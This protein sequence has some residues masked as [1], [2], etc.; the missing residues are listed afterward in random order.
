MIKKL[1]LRGVL[2]NRE[3]RV[4]SLLKKETAQRRESAAVLEKA[5]GNSLPAFVAAFLKDNKL[6]LPPNG[7]SWNS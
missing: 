2:E 7:R 5:F 1:A 4:T 3:A 6:S